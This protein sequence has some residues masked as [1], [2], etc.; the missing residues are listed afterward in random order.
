MNKHKQGNLLNGGAVLCHDPLDGYW[1]VC[2][3]PAV[4]FIKRFGGKFDL[5]AAHYDLF[6][7]EQ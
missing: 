6:I 2:A 3:Q 7:K 4:D 5:C 1:A